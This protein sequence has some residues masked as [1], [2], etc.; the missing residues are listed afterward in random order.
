M[1]PMAKVPNAISTMVVASTS[2]RPIR[3]ASGP[4]NSPP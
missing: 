3:S 1:H 4:K 2:L